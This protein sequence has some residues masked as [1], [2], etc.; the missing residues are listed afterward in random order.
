MKTV[1][2]PCGPASTMMLPMSSTT[3]RSRAQ[4]GSDASTARR[5]DH[6]CPETPWRSTRSVRTDDSSSECAVGTIGP[7]RSR[8]WAPRPSLDSE[9]RPDRQRS[10]WHQATT[11]P[12]CAHDLHVRAR[13]IDRWRQPPHRLQTGQVE[14]GPEPVELC[15]PVAL[16]PH[17]SPGHSRV[18][19][20]IRSPRATSDDRPTHPALAA[21]STQKS[22]VPARRPPRAAAATATTAAHPVRRPASGP[23]TRTGDRPWRQMA[24]YRIQQRDA[25]RLDIRARL[26]PRH[27]PRDCQPSRARSR[28]RAGPR[29]ARSTWQRRRRRDRWPSARVPAAPRTAGPT[30][31]AGSGPILWRR[32]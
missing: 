20:S 19:S 6:S 27:R 14:H 21:R 25:E 7:Q 23:A 11:P 2:G 29:S 5:T 4:A 9:Q 8:R 31:D 30:K 32:R 26:D 3:A 16:G 1:A 13:L 17:S 22:C 24:R 15:R 10:R 12:R 28:Q 18:S